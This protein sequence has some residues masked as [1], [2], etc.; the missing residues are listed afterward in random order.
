MAEMLVPVDVFIKSKGE[1][2]IYKDIAGN[3]A[4]SADKEGVRV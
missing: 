2:G 4:Y 3:I 1:F